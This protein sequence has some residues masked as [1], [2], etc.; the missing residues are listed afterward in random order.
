MEQDDYLEQD[1]KSANV[2]VYNMPVKLLWK[3]GCNALQF[4][5]Y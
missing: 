3:L 2:P 1:D 4:I 5:V